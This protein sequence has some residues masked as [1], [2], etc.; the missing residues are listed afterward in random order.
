MYINEG[1]CRFVLLCADLRKV[2]QI[3]ADLLDLNQFLHVGAH[4]YIFYKICLDFW[5]FVLI[6]ANVYRFVQICAYCADFCRFVQ[7]LNMYANIC[8]VVLICKIWTICVDWLWFVQTCK[9]LCR[10]VKIVHNWIA[11]WRMMRSC[12]TFANLCKFVQILK[13]KWKKKEHKQ[14][15]SCKH[16]ENSTEISTHLHK[17]AKIN[18]EMYRITW[19][20]MIFVEICRNTQNSM[21]FSKNLM[22]LH[23]YARISWISWI[24]KNSN[25]SA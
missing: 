1:L 4:F 24:C 13:K 23:E 16:K 14:A 15:E 2:V 7:N 8:G 3:R 10:V 11:V 22:N 20:Q 6:C 19:K 18:Q 17:Y 9:K 25:K 12:M 21:I 5:R